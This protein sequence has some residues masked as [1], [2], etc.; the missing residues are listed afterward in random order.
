MHDQAQV[1]RLLR[2]CQNGDKAAMSEL[3]EVVYSELRRLAAHY[4]KAERPGHTLQPTAL[5]HEAYLRLVG[6]GQRDWRDRAHFFAVAAETMRTLLVD[7]ARA[8]LAAKRG[9][10][11]VRMELSE[12]VG[13][14]VP[15]AE[16]LLALDEVLRRLSTQDARQAR[17]VELR[18]FG[19]LD[20]REVAAVLG[21][22]ERTVKREWS[23]AKAWL[24]AEL[25]VSSAKSSRT[26]ACPRQV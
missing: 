8:R 18:H 25:N 21:I 6:R 15:A 22:S 14:P 12:T 16:E 23:M 19:G 13:A 24:Y 26:K 9:G 7:H 17:I 1:T 11:P 3:I 10:S 4:M 20:N 2:D 5:V